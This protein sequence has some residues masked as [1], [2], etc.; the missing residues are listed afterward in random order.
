MIR[1]RSKPEFYVAK[2]CDKARK[3]D[4]KYEYRNYVPIKDITHEE[5][6]CFY[7]SV[8]NMHL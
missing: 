1:E 2:F 7:L 6:V 8:K 5:H 3:G 4:W